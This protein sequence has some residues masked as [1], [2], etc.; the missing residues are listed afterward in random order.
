[1]D[2]LTTTEER[3]LELLFEDLTTGCSIHE[4]STTLK[5][6]YPQVHRNVKSLIK[7]ELVDSKKIGKSNMI[8][9]KR[10]IVTKEYIITELN[11]R[12]KVIKKYT[13]LRR[14]IEDLEKVPKFQYICI[15]FGSYAKGNPKH[16]SDIDLL[17]IIP[18][19]YDYGKFEMVTKHTFITGHVDINIGLDESLHEM[20]SNPS[21]L[22]VGN[23]LLKG[24]IVLKGAE[25]F[26]EAWRKHNVG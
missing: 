25:G 18:K 24:H 12:D 21:K 1:M 4:I 26:L 23:E 20:W 14:V 13:A 17:F 7:R 5:I 15:L 16:D 2:A 9:L 6:P 19:D 22:N 3:I 10:D 11:R 8:S